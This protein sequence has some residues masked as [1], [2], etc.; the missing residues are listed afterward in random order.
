MLTER[1]RA[2][3]NH[4]NCQLFRLESAYD[5]MVVKFALVFGWTKIG[6]DIDVEDR[7]SVDPCKHSDL[8]T[9]V[10]VLVRQGLVLFKT[11]C[12]E[13]NSV[14]ISTS[15]GLCN[16]L[17]QNLLCSVIVLCNEEDRLADACGGGR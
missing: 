10:V 13:C 11:T 7:M 9:H 15:S 17:R 12:V 8:L 3:V 14:V 5:H 16:V 1:W 2:R 4:H 6:Q